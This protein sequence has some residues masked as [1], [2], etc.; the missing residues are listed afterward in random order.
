MELDH[1]SSVFRRS[2]KESYHNQSIQIRKIALLVDLEQEQSQVVLRQCQNY[3]AVLGDTPEWVVVNIESDQEHPSALA[4]RCQA[5]GAD[6]L[7]TY[8]HLGTPFRDIP[9]SLGMYL[10]ALSQMVETPLLILPRVSDEDYA[11][12]LNNTNDVMVMTDHLSGDHRLIDYG[13][14]FTPVQSG[15][16]VLTHVESQSVL[17]YYLRAIGKIPALS[18]E[19]AEEQL[20]LQLLKEPR[21][22]MDSSR[23]LIQSLRPELKLETVAC[24][25]GHLETYSE[26][27]QRYEI[28]L[29][30][31]NAKDEGQIAMHGDVYALA[32][33][34]KHI[35]L[36]LL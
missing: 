30:I 29:L 6:L 35:P 3:L 1:M 27:L 2:I 24:F 34:M 14:H 25:G 31:L 33:E 11:H 28:D 12:V 18:T 26:L 9:H 15:R 13:L 19:L 4:E 5:L 20:P 16:L 32:V 22:F 23:E 21:E 8:R 10:D 17:D 7:I 36:L